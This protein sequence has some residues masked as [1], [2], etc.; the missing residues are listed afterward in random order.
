MES[1]TLAF[2]FDAT[3]SQLI[4]RIKEVQFIILI[5]VKGLQPSPISKNKISPRL[6]QSQSAWQHF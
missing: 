1:T 3:N 6:L 2:I 5:E 4:K